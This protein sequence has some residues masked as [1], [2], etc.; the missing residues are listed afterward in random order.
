MPPIATRDTALSSVRARATDLPSF[1]FLS[2]VTNYYLGSGFCLSLSKAFSVLAPVLL[3]FPFFSWQS[4]QVGCIVCG[5]LAWEWRTKVNSFSPRKQ[6]S[7]LVSSRV[8]QA[9]LSVQHLK[10]ERKKLVTH[11]TVYNQFESL[12][13]FLNSL[14]TTATEDNGHAA[15]SCES[16]DFEW[17]VFDG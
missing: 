11:Y 9:K 8:D 14:G 5:S 17:N 6:C 12:P 10:R 1:C 4:S 7:R 15:K 3:V 13:T 16:F 2:V